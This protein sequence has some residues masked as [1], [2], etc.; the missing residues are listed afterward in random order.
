MRKNEVYQ[1]S[2]GVTLE[3]L[4]DSTCTDLSCCGKP[5]ELLQPKAPAQEGKEKHV[6][7]VSEGPKGA[8]VTVG[9]VPH[10]MEPDHYIQW[11]EIINGDYVNRKYLA[12]GQKP[13]AEFYVPLQSGLIVREYCNKHGLW[14][15]R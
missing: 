10:P 15:T 5:M 4:G 14:E 3:V 9:S 6:P 8:K 1:C 11:I 2:P 12:P 13:E 7:V